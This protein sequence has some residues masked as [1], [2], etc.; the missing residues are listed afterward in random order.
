[1]KLIRHSARFAALVGAVLALASCDSRSPTNPGGGGTGGDPSDLSAPV[2]TFALSAG[3]NKTLDIGTPLNVTITATDDKGIQSLLTTLWNG[4]TSLDSKDT[5]L[6]PTALTTSRV[7]AVPT[8]GLQKGDKIIVR[9]AASDAS[10][11]FSYDSVVV[12][13]VDITAPKISTFFSSKNG[14]ALT[15][16]D[17]LD[18]HMTASDSS[19]MQKLGYRVYRTGGPDSLTVVTG[20]SIMAGATTVTSMDSAFNRLLPATLNIGTYK[21]VGFATDRSGISTTPNPTLSFTIVDRVKP[22]IKFISPQFGSTLN[23]GDSLL[24][25]VD[26]HD[27]VGLK[28]VSFYAVSPR[29]DIALGTADTIQRYQ[30]VTAPQGGA[31]FRAGLTD[32]LTIRRLLPPVMPLDTLPGK[33]L[34]YGVVTDAAGNVTRDTVVITMT[35]GP[36]VRLLAPVSGDSLTRGTKLRI[37]ISASSVVGVTKMGFD[38]AGGL[39]G[40]AWPTPID[41]T[42]YEISL[43][44]SASNPP[45]YTVDIEIPADAPPLGVLTIWPHAE[46]VNGQPGRP[47]PQDFLVRVGA[48]PPPLVHQSIAARVELKDSVTIYASGASLTQVGY[49]ISEAVPPYARVDSQSVTASSSSFGPKGV[50]F[51]L[52]TKWQGKR[53]RISSFARDSAGKIGWSAPSGSTSPITDTTKMVRDTA[54]V[55]Y[56]RTYSLPTGRDGLIADVVVD[57][58]RGHVFLSNISSSRLEVWRDT[59]RTFDANG[60]FVGSQPW[61]MALSRTAAGRDTMYV[62]NSGGTNLSRVYIGDAAP[63]AEDLPNRILTR[64]SLLY[65]ITEVRDPSTSKIR[66]TVSDPIMFSDRPQYI[67]QAASGRVYLSTKPTTASGQKGTIRYLAPNAAAPDQRFILAFASPGNDPNSYLVANIDAASVVPAPATSP[68]SDML[69]LCD[70]AT[71]TTD[72]QTCASST[73]GIQATIDAL[74]LVVPTTDLE[75]AANLDETSLGLTD[76]T[77][78]AASGDGQWIAFGEGNR[79]PYSRAFLLHDDGSVPG[80]YD[81]ASPSLN[82]QDLI[83]NASDQIFGVALGKTGK[84]LALHGAETYFASVSKP[85]TQRLQ[86]KYATFSQGAGIALHPNADDMTTTP[87]DARLSFVASNNGFIEVVDIGYYTSRGALATKYNLYGPLRASLPFPTDDPSVILKLFGLSPKGLVVIDVTATDIKAGP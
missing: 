85:F 71:G 47:S 6:K 26:L 87:A 41:S 80:T 64:I 30:T 54:L 38:V 75:A 82:I 69:T 65:K 34:V 10:N 73:G 72:G 48:A 49:V 31:T 60:I 1:M 13:I 56:G 62:A 11:N 43:S 66:I 74:R 83:N 12:T 9:A 50:T 5:T 77:Y 33:L 35:K 44:P 40:P 57:Q 8:S 79:S 55:V 16:G 70:H 21:I 36:N 15:G 25:K 61:G 2:I 81:Y 68:A 32:T 42:T 37:S 78:A 17:S 24:V 7:V 22:T 59:T 76:T 58:S 3:T 86:G 51:D 63:M 52:A 53:I 19:G 18:V 67:Q 14:Q 39:T 23:A 20:D 84:T 27:N 29:G 46:D 45:V 28:N 4:A